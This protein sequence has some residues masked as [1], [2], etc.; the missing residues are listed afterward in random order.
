MLQLTLKKQTNKK[1][2]MH[3]SVKILHLVLQG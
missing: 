3:T 1:H 2:T